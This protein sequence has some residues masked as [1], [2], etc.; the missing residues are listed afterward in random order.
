VALV[1]TVFVVASLLYGLTETAIRAAALF[2][3]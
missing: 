1:L 2:V 3:G